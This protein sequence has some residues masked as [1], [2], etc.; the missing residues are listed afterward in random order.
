MIRKS[1]KIEIQCQI[2]TH[3]AFV[4]FW[5][6]KSSWC[7]EGSLWRIVVSKYLADLTH[8]SCNTSIEVTTLE[9]QLF[10]CDFVSIKTQM[11]SIMFIWVKR[12]KICPFAYLMYNSHNRKIVSNYSQ[13]NNNNNYLNNIAV[14]IQTCVFAVKLFGLTPLI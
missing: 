14:F 13:L 3:V 1:H 9:Q 12:V 7:N 5:F 10:S 11:Q 6:L 8:L 2:V 4:H